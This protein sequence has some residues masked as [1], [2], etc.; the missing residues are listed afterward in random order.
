MG[1]QKQ[2]KE[3][4]VYGDGTKGLKNFVS[5]LSFFK[6]YKWYIISFVL[7]EFIP[8][9]IGIIT[10]IYSAK[11][12]AALTNNELINI[13]IFAAVMYGGYI[14]QEATIAFI[15]YF[16]LSK[17]IY[18]ASYDMKMQLTQ[19][20]L[21]LKIQNFDKVHSGFFLRVIDASATSYPSQLINII[22]NI[23]TIFTRIFYM[24]FSLFLNVWL[25]LFIIASFL[26]NMLVR[27]LRI[28]WRT[29]NRKKLQEKGDIVT[30]FGN[31]TLRGIRDI[32][33]SKIEDE[34]YAKNN[35]L[36][37]E[38]TNFE[39]KY[40]NKLDIF[41][42]LGSILG[43]FLQFVFI[44][45]I[46]YLLYLEQIDPII[47]L[48]VYNFYGK[49]I[50]L[51]VVLNN[52]MQQLKTSEYDAYRINQ[53]LSGYE[54]GFEKFGSYEIDMSSKKDIQ[55]KNVTFA[56]KEEQVLKNISFKIKENTTVGIAGE[57]GAGK[58][59]IIRLL[60]KMYDVS[61]GE[62]IV[63]GSNIQDLSR[64]SLRKLITVIPQD[65][66]IFNMTFRENLTIVKPDAT[67]EEIVDAFTK[68]QLYD[69][70]TA[71]KD[72][73]DTKLGEN[74]IVLSGGQKQRLAIARGLL[75][76]SPIL[77]L[78]EATSSLD[79]ENQEKIKHVIASLSGSRSVIIIAHRLSTIIDADEIL[80]IK[81]GKVAKRGTHQYL[82]EN[83]KEYKNFYKMEN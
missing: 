1:K 42:R 66:Y 48:T 28:N 39:L 26:I 29:K 5:L 47:A 70:I 38:Y 15:N 33:S 14:L 64:E 71:Q 20:I 54:F 7:L 55:F 58:S 53:V 60:S 8:V 69:F 34:V 43:F 44:G 41:Y 22:D 73:L 79:N 80:F 46:V 68:A 50:N 16:I 45:L 81:K 4:K 37:K 35:N 82:M 40:E 12:L 30:S 72:G 61:D 75:V 10:P 51:S 21:S 31:E 63:A 25:G 24:G 49:A 13:L 9:G 77:I 3:Y 32:K 23:F 27:F 56:Y 76:A 2:E 62:V 59:T 65:P 67:E 6:P 52:L 11:F 36:Q 74:G 19:K 18:K 17:F 83:C 78:D 57:S